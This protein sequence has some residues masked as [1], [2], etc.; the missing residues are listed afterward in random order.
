MKGKKRVFKRVSLSADEL[1][2]ALLVPPDHRLLSAVLSVMDGQREELMRAAGEVGLDAAEA[3]AR[4]RAAEEL[5][6]SADEIVSLVEVANRRQ[7]VG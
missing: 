3:M 7:G 1:E 2:L 5:R 4:A 6:V